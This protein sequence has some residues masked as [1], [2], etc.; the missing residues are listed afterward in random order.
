MRI[1]RN[2]KVE[3]IRCPVS[4]YPYSQETLIVTDV[5]QQP[6][7]VHFV[8]TEEE[9]GRKISSLQNNHFSFKFKFEICESDGSVF[10]TNNERHCVFYL[11]VE[12]GSM[13]PVIGVYD[14]AGEEDGTIEIAELSRPSGNA[15][16]G[17]VIYIAEHPQEYQGAV[18]VMYSLKGLKSFQ[19]IWRGT[20]YSM[21][22][23]SKRSTVNDTELAKTV[24]TRKLTGSH[25]ELKAP[26][27]QLKY[28]VESTIERTE[29]ESLDITHGSMAS[30]TDKA[31]YHTLVEAQKLLLQYFDHVKHSELLN[32]SLAEAFFGHIAEQ[33]SS[34]NLTFIQMARLI[35][36]EAFHYLLVVLTSP[37]TSGVS[38]RRTR[39]E[40]SGK[41]FNSK[42][43]DNDQSD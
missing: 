28:L 17:S 25:D 37:E 31:V 5:E 1:I 39:H 41:S 15:V 13:A 36:K 40:K 3:R 34:N 10:V 22:L 6:P 35:P 23:I 14:D 38:V 11:G 2:M 8:T 32:D 33:V 26:A 16:R 29:A 7:G 18:P 24:I 19:T 21:G 9:E 4:C 42:I 27:Q 20:A 12:P 30:R 43:D